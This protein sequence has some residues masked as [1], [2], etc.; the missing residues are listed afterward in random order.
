MYSLNLI[1]G[2][3]MQALTNDIGFPSKGK[4]A[5]IE[6][7][8][9]EQ[10]SITLT[11]ETL[12]DA[13][14]YSLYRASG[15]F[16]D[17]CFDEIASGITG[18]SYTDSGLEANS[19]YY[20][21]IVPVVNGEK[22]DKR[23]SGILPVAVKP[24]DIPWATAEFES[25]GFFYMNNSVYR[26]MVCGYYPYGTD[27]CEVMY[28]LAGTDD[29]W[30]EAEITT[31]NNGDNYDWYFYS[32]GIPAGRY[33][34]Q[35]T[36]YVENIY[37][38][39][40]Y[41]NTVAAE[42]W[43]MYPSPKNGYAEY[44]ESVGKVTLTWD[45]VEGASEYA[46]YY[47]TDFSNHSVTKL[48]I[49]DTCTFIHENVEPGTSYVYYVCVCNESI[50]GEAL[51][52]SLPAEITMTTSGKKMYRT[53]YFFP[54]Q[55]GDNRY[56]G[57]EHEATIQVDSGIKDVG[58]F[59]VYYSPRGE[60]RWTTDKP[61]NAGVY[62]VAVDIAE[63]DTYAAVSK[64]RDDD[65]EIEIHR[66]TIMVIPD[67]NIQKEEGDEDPVLTYT[68]R[69]NV[70]GEIP[71][72]TGELSRD[73]GETMGQ[74]WI[75][76]GTLELADNG[77]FL[78]ANYEMDFYDDYATMGIYGVMFDKP[79]VTIVSTTK[80]SGVIE[81][82]P[83]RKALGYVIYDYWDDEILGLTSNTTFEITGLET[84]TSYTYRIY[85]YRSFE[86]VEDL[87]RFTDFSFRT[88]P[89]DVLT[90][91][92]FIFSAENAVYDEMPHGATIT[93]KIPGVEIRSIVYTSDEHPQ[94]WSEDLPVYPGWY[95]VAIDTEYND[96][97][98]RAFYLRDESWEFTIGKAT[99]PGSL[100]EA[101][102]L[103]FTNGN[104]NLIK[105]YEDSAFVEYALGEDDVNPPADGWDYTIPMGEKAGTY[106]V[107]YRS[108]GKDAYIDIPP[109]CLLVTI[110]KYPDPPFKPEPVLQCWYSSKKVGDV[111][112]SYGWSWADEDKDRVFVGDESITATAVY[113]GDNCDC[114]ENITT[115]VTI[116]RTWCSHDHVTMTPAK[117]PTQ[118]EP[119]NITF[120]TCDDCGKYFLDEGLSIIEK[121]D[122]FIPALGGKKGD[123]D[124]DNDI[125]PKDVT[126]LRRHL[127]GGWIV[128]IIEANADVDGDGD[129]TPKDVTILRRYLAG[130]WGVTLG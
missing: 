119:G 86:N 108:I 7:A 125:T 33:E 22:D 91:D 95:L 118:T 64:L 56:D 127:A 74:Y 116:I 31:Y 79:E 20:Y 107:W 47:K 87:Y 84:D 104:Q 114:Y 55:Y 80:H 105:C 76:G 14:S 49:T 109:T 100:P 112:V 36:P 82:E 69:G 51:E 25:A 11:W 37:G 102:E 120:W 1:R 129:I 81:W 78:A 85:P 63:T 48:G 58:A 117:E 3:W 96:E 72:F 13:D 67:E 21:Q 113:T 10:D 52:Y 6:V 54:I 34:L 62:L 122:W 32:D 97:Y 16:G 101:A 71:G 93:C 94:W 8:D 2:E 27:G 110:A 12:T 124:G 65:W 99:L 89:R 23:A 59:T 28:R 106:Y 17:D 98:E 68:Y 57:N 130:G 77:N 88:D 44:D 123:A 39:R 90:A 26:Q 4:I 15:M 5:G 61:V 29:E 103:T 121:K 46:L 60:F 45:A 24:S 18:N 43:A 41:G 40:A 35:I 42:F 73:E 66:S 19:L 83:V 9:R 111:E 115:S 30:Q 128:T 70:E 53:Q 92:N 126:M 50:E 38:E 75:H